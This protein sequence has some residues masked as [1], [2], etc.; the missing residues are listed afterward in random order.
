MIIK[1]AED[2]QLPIKALQSLLAHPEADTNTRKRIEREILNIKAGA[3][4]EEEAAYEIKVHWGE[5]KNWMIIHD[6]RI[7]HGGLVA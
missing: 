5:S 7:E 4:G 3:R 6:L 1:H 2:K